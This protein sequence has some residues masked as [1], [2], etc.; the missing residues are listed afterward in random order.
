[1]IK[2]LLKQFSTN[3]NISASWKDLVG[4]EPNSDRSLHWS[5]ENAAILKRKL[6]FHQG[7]PDQLALEARRLEESFCQEDDG[8]KWMK[9]DSRVATLASPTVLMDLGTNASPEYSPHRVP[10]GSSSIPRDIK[11]GQIPSF[12]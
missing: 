2:G 5:D 8:G 10:S 6:E 9:E 4:W 11:Q 3:F 12:I 7:R 1:V